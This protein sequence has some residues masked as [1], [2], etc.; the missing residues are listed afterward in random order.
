MVKSTKVTRRI[1]CTPI[2]DI[3]LPAPRAA[4]EKTRYVNGNCRASGNTV[5]MLTSWATLILPR[6]GF[7]HRIAADS[8]GKGAD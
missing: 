5:G 1:S 4:W 8:G 7:F 3:D 2:S 6:F